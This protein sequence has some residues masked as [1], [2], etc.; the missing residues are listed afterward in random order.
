MI[1]DATTLRPEILAIWV[2]SIRTT[3]NW[4]QEALA[5][6]AGVNV[7]TVQRVEKG[8]PSTINTRRALARGLGYDDFGVFDDPSFVQTVEG[9][10]DTIGTASREA[11]GRQHPDHVPVEIRPVQGGADLEQLV[12]RAQAIVFHCEDQAPRP[13]R[14]SVAAMFDLMGDLKDLWVE[15]SFGQRLGYRDDLARLKDEIEGHGMDLY[16]ALRPTRLVG[17][18]WTDKT[19]VS[20]T[21]GYLTIVSNEKKLTSIMVPRKIM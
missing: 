7:R 5:A 13:A 9:M 1:P 19:P 20:T 3:M 6:A 4:S 2:R 10:L 14:E 12:D 15:M 21:I 11:S 18:S 8:E 16:W 17:E